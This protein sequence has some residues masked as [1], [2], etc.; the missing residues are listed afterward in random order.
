MKT[1]WQAF[2]D[3]EPTCMGWRMGDGDGYQADYLMWLKSRPAEEREAIIRD[4]PEPQGWE[5]F[6]SMLQDPYFS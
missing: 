3:Y 5:H 1:P 2:P 6:Y 4:N